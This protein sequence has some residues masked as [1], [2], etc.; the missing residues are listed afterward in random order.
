MT[1]KLVLVKGGTWRVHGDAPAGFH[2]EGT[3]R[4][5]EELSEVVDLAL[6]RLGYELHT[7]VAGNVEAQFTYGRPG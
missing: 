3:P 1:V 5:T 7:L 6:R 4:G 2:V